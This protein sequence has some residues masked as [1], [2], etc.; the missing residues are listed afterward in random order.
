MTIKAAYNI[1]FG[2]MT[3]DPALP[4]LFF[5]YCAAAVW[6]DGTLLDIKF[7]PEL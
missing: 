2:V 5:C 7:Y 1:R 4:Q 6:R 3:A